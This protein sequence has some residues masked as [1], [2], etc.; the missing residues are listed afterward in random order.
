MHL[1]NK[2]THSHQQPVKLFVFCIFQ[3]LEDK[4]LFGDT[5]INV[6]TYFMKVI[7]ILS[8]YKLNPSPIFLTSLN[9]SNNYIQEGGVRNTSD[10]SK[11]RREKSYTT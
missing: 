3:N 8:L 10:N 1:V 6:T 11:I 7:K 5:L 4:L 9:E 2:I